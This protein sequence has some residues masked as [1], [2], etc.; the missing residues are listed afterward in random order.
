MNDILAEPSGQS[1]VLRVVDGQSYIVHQF[2]ADEADAIADD[3]HDSVARVR[4]AQYA[5]TQGVLL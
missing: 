3:L 2:S 1:V 5:N 4:A